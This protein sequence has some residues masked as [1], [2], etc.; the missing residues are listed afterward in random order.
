MKALMLAAALAA[1]APTLY[2]QTAED[3]VLEIIGQLFDGMR[4][5]D[6]AKVRAT[7]HPSMSMGSVSRNRDGEPQFRSGDAEGWVKA[8]G[9]PHD[10]QWDERIWDPVVHVDDLLAT[11][12][13]PYAF[14]LGDELSH[15][16]VNAFQLFKGKDG[17]TI[18]RVTD[19][20]RRNG[21]AEGGH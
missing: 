10:R 12:W 3:E 9:T 20:R 11:A 6:S 14:Y 1:G 8:V 2:A 19:T 4:A 16:G 7:L 18:I 5:G 15:C 17:W 21:C 13:V